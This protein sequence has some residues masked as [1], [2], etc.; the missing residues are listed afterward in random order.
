MTATIK[1]RQIRDR[2][3]YVLSNDLYEKARSEGCR[4]VFLTDLANE[5]LFIGEGEISQK[6]ADEWEIGVDRK[7][8]RLDHLTTESL[9]MTEYA[10]KVCGMDN[11]DSKIG[12]AT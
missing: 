1:W 12:E 9:D 2:L 8:K 10:K 4:E 6:E 7:D 5:M 3:D 11:N